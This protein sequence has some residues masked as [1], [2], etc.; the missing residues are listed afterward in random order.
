LTGALGLDGVLPVGEKDHAR[1]S[2]LVPAVGEHLGAHTE[3]L[4]DVGPRQSDDD[5]SHGDL[6]RCLARVRHACERGQ[7]GGLPGEGYHGEAVVGPELIDDEA[8]GSFQQLDLVA[9]HAVADVE[10]G[11]E[12]ERRARH[13]GGRLGVHEHGELVPGRAP[14]EGRELA[15]RL[16]DQTAV[17]SRR[18]RGLRL[19]GRQT[20]QRL[21]V[22]QR[23]VVLVRAGRSR[24]RRRRVLLH[25]RH[26]LHVA[27][28]S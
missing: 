1:D 10:H 21:I 18:W 7:A 4:T 12:I 20:P 26:R 15:L 8:H 25:V 23:L 19:G 17:G 3:V 6:R 2:V 27:M 28:A 14:P 22:R 5:V 24:S 16:E 11:H 9:L 13:V